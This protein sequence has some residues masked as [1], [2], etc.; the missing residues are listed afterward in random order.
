MDNKEMCPSKKAKTMKINRRL[1]SFTFQSEPRR[2]ISYRPVQERLRDYQEVQVNGN[3]EELTTQADRCM[4]CGV[5]FCHSGCPLG[6]FIP[7][8]N[9]AVSAGDWRQAYDI[10][11]S[12]NNFP[13]FTGRICPAPCESACVLGIHKDPVTIENL[14][15]T[16]IEEAFINGWVEPCISPERPESIAIIGSGPAGL[17]AA[18]Q[19]S[20]AGY[21]V[22]VF[23]KNDAPGGL[24]R[25]G[26]P[27]F[28]LNKNVLDRRIALMQ[29]QGV[30]FHC[31][32]TWGIDFELSDLQKEHDAILIAIGSEIARD[33]LIEGRNGPGVHLAMEYL[34]GSNQYVGGK[35]NAAPINVNGEQVIIIGGGDTGADC[36]GTA[37]RQGAASVLQLELMPMPP[38]QRHIDTPWPNWP[39]MM[40]TSTSHEEGGERQWSIQ[41]KS[42]VRNAHHRL[43]GLEVIDVEWKYDRD[44]DR[45][46]FFEIEG[47]QRIIP[48]DRVFLALGFVHPLQTILQQEGIVRNDRGLI[49]DQHYQTNKA[50]IF[51]AGDARRGQSLVVWAIQE[52]REAAKAIENYLKMKSDENFIANASF[53]SLKY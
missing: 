52:G 35:I 40:R 50:G 48:C 26:I 32:K 23:E 20:K 34:M 22:Q 10:L 5:P 43:V 13:E 11:I 17:A 2:P 25:Y 29:Q 46:K 14:E 12:T 27:D 8:F 30:V 19:L 38:N 37:H 16:I 45:S 44:N 39:L 49:Q 3:K 47:T 7:D 33:L 1:P 28:K 42:F 9:A 41:T 53:Q 51:T 31:E 18:D 21:S 36:V 24:L 15:K 6:N 4:D